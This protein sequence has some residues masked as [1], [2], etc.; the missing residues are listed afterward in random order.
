[1]LFNA[2]DSI[3]ERRELAALTVEEFSEFLAF[4]Y[5]AC[6]SR[7]SRDYLDYEPRENAG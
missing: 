7:T 3:A 1:M 5:A 6:V 2:A 4:R